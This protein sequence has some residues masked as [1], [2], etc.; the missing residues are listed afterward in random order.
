MP[1]ALIDVL[2][3]ASR[4]PMPAVWMIDTLCDEVPQ[5]CF[6]GREDIPYIPLHL[7]RVITKIC[8]LLG[9][10]IRIRVCVDIAGFKIPLTDTEEVDH[11]AVPWVVELVLLMCS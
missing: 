2:Q 4:N 6:L 3:K 5:G 8:P 1:E 11:S 10:R 7:V 9:G